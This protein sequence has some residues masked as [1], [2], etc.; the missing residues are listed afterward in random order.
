MVQVHANLCAKTN[1]KTYAIHEGSTSWIHKVQRTV[2][3]NQ[4]T[5]NENAKNI[6][7]Q[8]NTQFQPGHY[9]KHKG[10]HIRNCKHNNNTQ[11]WTN[12]CT[13]MQPNTTQLPEKPTPHICKMQ[14]LH[15]QCT[16][17]NPMHKTVHRPRHNPGHSPGHSPMHSQAGHRPRHRPDHSPGHRPG[18]SPA[19][20]TEHNTGHRQDQGT[21]QTTGQG[22]SQHTC[23]TTTS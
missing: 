18:H 22:T 17:H 10:M 3:S 19:H 21:G 16:G 20:S 7:N 4:R 6:D 14:K 5:Q 15:L 13:K 8:S 12:A 2:A 11:H 1:A 9:T 23:H